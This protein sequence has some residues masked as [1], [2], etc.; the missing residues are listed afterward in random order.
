MTGLIHPHG[1]QY[2]FGLWK[3]TLGSAS[4][5]Q[6]QWLEETVGQIST[7]R[8]LAICKDPNT[9]HSDGIEIDQLL[10]PERN[11]QKH[12]MGEAINRALEIIYQPAR[13]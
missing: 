6:R 4:S 12:L 7:E 9:T 3:L 13:P 2:G 1:A 11:R 10:E 8:I 5:A